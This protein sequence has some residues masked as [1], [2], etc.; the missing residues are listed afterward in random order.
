[1]FRFGVATKYLLLTWVFIFIFL[2]LTHHFAETT[3]VWGFSD[4][5]I[6]FFI[7]LFDLYLIFPFK[8]D[9]KK[10]WRHYRSKM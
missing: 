9:R 6:L 2:V 4:L 5:Y 10:E 1:M 8:V 3:H 7:L